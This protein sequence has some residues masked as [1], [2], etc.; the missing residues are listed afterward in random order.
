MGA[1]YTISPAPWSIL[2]YSI[3]AWWASGKITDSETS[4]RRRMGAWVDC[5][6]VAGIVVLI[7]D[8]LWVGAVWIRWGP[9][10][11]EE[12]P[13][14]VYSQIRN[15]ALLGVSLIMSWEMWK[16]L[17]ISWGKDV[18]LL[19]G[20]DIIYLTFWFGTAPSL[21]YTH[22]VYALENG[23][24]AWLYAWGMG[25]I[26]GRMITTLIYWRTWDVKQDR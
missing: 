8:I 9:I 20:L 25:Y 10:Y 1:W 22:W 2:M 7:G 12:I 26:V 3:W 18:A 21:E 4:F 14:L 19:W 17:W 23:Y 16:N 15:V 6:W 24:S 11:P 5:V 13:L